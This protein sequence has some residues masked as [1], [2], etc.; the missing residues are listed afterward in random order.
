M[1]HIIIPVFL[2]Q[3]W[4]RISSKDIITILDEIRLHFE[5]KKKKHQRALSSQIFTT[6]PKTHNCSTIIASLGTTWVPKEAKFFRETNLFGFVR[7]FAVKI[8]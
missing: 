6:K 3:M 2:G 4:H 5:K 7:C 8:E 1:Q